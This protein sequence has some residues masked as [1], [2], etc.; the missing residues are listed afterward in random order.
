MTGGNR[1]RTK[2]LITTDVPLSL[3]EII[4]SKPYETTNFGNNETKEIKRKKKDKDKTTTSHDPMLLQPPTPK[5][6]QVEKQGKKYPRT[7][8]KRSP[9]LN[10]QNIPTP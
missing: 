2:A 8:Y 6:I 1:G 3:P 10:N 4:L 9:F 7:Q 5:G